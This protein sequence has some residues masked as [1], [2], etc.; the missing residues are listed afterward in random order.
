MH[1]SKLS[2]S[3]PCLK[4]LTLSLNYPTQEPRQQ[5]PPAH[6]YP[7]FSNVFPNLTHFS[8]KGRL[9]SPSPAILSSFLSLHPHLC[10]LTYYGLERDIVLP[11]N[12]L[13]NLEYLEANPSFIVAI[14][15]SSTIPRGKLM[16]LESLNG[17][18]LEIKSTYSLEVLPKLPNLHDLSIEYNGQFTPEF[19]EALGKSCLYL[20]TLKLHNPLWVGQKVSAVCCYECCTSIIPNSKCFLQ[21]R[22]AEAFKPFKF[23]TFFATTTQFGRVGRNWNNPPDYALSVLVARSAPA[24]EVVELGT[25]SDDSRWPPPIVLNVERGEDGAVTGVRYFDPSRCT[26]QNVELAEG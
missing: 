26:Y 2:A 24:L 16:R 7:L 10:S 12:L 5:F 3:N 20:Q 13:P 8:L 11:P 4:E 21:E 22:F 14:C 18:Q 9:T 23:L 6:T 17:W 1:L 19:I 25:L 15:R